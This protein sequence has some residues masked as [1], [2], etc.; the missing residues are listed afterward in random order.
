MGFWS[1]VTSDKEKADRIFKDVIAT[2]NS[3]VVRHVNNSIQEYVD[4]EDGVHLVKLRPTENARGYRHA[5]LWIDKNIPQD[6]AYEV[7]L[8]KFMGNEND[9]VWI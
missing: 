2:H 4:F 1:I 9:I 3:N 5:K 8:P 7:F 6:I